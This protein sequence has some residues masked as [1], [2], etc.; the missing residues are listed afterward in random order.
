[1]NGPARIMIV[2]GEPSGDL[3]GAGV[4]REL[5]RRNPACDVFGIGGDLMI[6]AGLDAVFHIRELSVMGF[7]EVVRHL[8][9]LKAVERT[10]AALLRGRRPDIVILIDYPGF[11]LRFARRV[12]AENIP[13]AYYIS[14]Q[15][16]AWRPGRIKKMKGIVDTMLVVF[17]FETALYEKAGIPVRFVGHPLLEV[18]TD[19]PGRGEF[20]ARHGFSGDHPVVALFPGSRR[21]EIE[22]IFP[23]MLGAARLINEATGAQIAVGVSPVLEMEYMR[24]F[25]RGQEY[26]RLI[27]DAS[28]DIMKN[29]DLA[30][31]TSG[32][33]TL[34]TGYYRT[35]MIVV[36]KM[37]RL[38]YVIIRPLIRI[39]SIGLVNIVA[40][41]P[42][43]PEL[44]QGRANAETIA[45]EAVALLRDPGRRASMSKAL[46]V[47]RE[48]LGSPG[49]S[50]RV[51]DAVYSMCH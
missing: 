41:G 22:R 6:S 14:P 25:L 35:P 10:L 49:A 43:V 19:P 8:P 17:P 42:V 36:Y 46:G 3:H 15:I 37:S 16:W 7:W 40:G 5:K 29:A 30:V 32:T 21:Q 51:V 26:I 47:I 48:K 1:M 23:A 28:Y 18:L 4:V 33:A 20:L 2:A 13:V 39:R 31:V 27:Q 34:E 24:S 44:I 11:N 9:T 12:K 50:A 45:T 38:T